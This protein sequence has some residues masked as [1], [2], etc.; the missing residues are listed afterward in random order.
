MNEIVFPAGILQPPFF[1]P[2]GRRRG[3]LRRHRRRDRPRN[4]ARLRRPGPPVRRRGQPARL[5]DQGGRARSSRQRADMVG[6]Q[7][8]AFSPLD[9]VF[10]NGKLTMGENLADLGGLNIAY[11]FAE[12]AAEEISE[13]DVPKYRRLHARAAL[14]PVVGPDL[15]HQRPARVPTP[16]GADRLALA[17]PVPHQRP[18]DEHAPVL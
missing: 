6:K 14:L 8:S 18:A 17:G 9:S 12:A 13:G 2:Q 15:A 1:D 10:V 5:V 4:D 11:R 16:A 7:Y 3:E